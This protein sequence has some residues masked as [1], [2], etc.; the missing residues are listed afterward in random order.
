MTTTKAETGESA[1]SR[2]NAAADALV[3]KLTSVTTTHGIG[4]SCNIEI[5]ETALRERFGLNDNSYVLK[6]V[7]AHIWSNVCG[8]EK[9]TWS[10]ADVSKAI[11]SCM[12]RL[13]QMTAS[14][15]RVV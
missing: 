7:A 15:A 11:S 10:Q 12:Y 6:A 5:I 14:L 2:V 1:V 9:A 13:N 3:E 4:Y 8:S